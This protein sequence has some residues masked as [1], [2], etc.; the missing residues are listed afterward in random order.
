[1]S[2]E[3]IIDLTRVFVKHG[4]LDSNIIRDLQVKKE[5]SELRSSGVSCKE[6]R[7]RLSE[8]Y[9]T[10]EKNIEHILY[11][12]KRKKQPAYNY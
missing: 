12:D 7:R 5:Y 1:M 11:S 10:S 9:N 8:K 2:E 4:L 3:L 6:A